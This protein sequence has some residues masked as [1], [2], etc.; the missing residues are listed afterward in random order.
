M[1]FPTAP[2]TNTSPIA[3]QHPNVAARS[4]PSSI[5]PP[6]PGR[7]SQQLRQEL[8]N[9]RDEL[10]RC[11]NQLSRSTSSLA[12][13]TS[14]LELYVVQS[15]SDLFKALSL[16]LTN[17]GSDWIEHGLRGGLTHAQFVRLDVETIRDIRAE[18]TQALDSFKAASTEATSDLSP[19]DLRYENMPWDQRDQ[20]RS[21]AGQQ[22]HG[23]HIFISAEVLDTLETLAEVLTATLIPSRDRSQPDTV[24]LGIHR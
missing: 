24:S 22:Q 13:G 15:Y 1:T 7:E 21:Q 10:Q 16:I 3:I 19:W 23:D 12:P 17:H 18:L 20:A 9:L 2:R 11:I 6:G 14:S 4:N 5:P 8:Y